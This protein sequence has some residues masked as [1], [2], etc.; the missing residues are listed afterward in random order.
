VYTCPIAPL[1]REIDI[2][3]SVYLHDRAAVR[4]SD[5]VSEISSCLMDPG[6]KQ[7]CPYAQHCI[8]DVLGDNYDLTNNK[9]NSANLHSQNCFLCAKQSPR[10]PPHALRFVSHSNKESAGVQECCRRSKC[11]DLICVYTE[12]S[13]CCSWHGKIAMASSCRPSD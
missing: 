9:F 4:T 6:V 11:C 5:R 12:Q 10:E 8:V 1:A 2:I 13:K 7:G 3:K